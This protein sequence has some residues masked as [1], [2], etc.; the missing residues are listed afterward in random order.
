[1][2]P[3]HNTRIASLC[4]HADREEGKRQGYGS[5]DSLTVLLVQKPKKWHYGTD[6]DRLWTAREEQFPKSPCVLSQQQTCA[7]TARKTC[8]RRRHFSVETHTSS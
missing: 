1:M 8:A 6:K 4:R 5:R 2:P 3:E 7:F